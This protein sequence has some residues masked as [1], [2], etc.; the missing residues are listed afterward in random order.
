[1]KPVP[2]IGVLLVLLAALS[3]ANDSQRAWQSGTLLC[4]TTDAL[5]I[6]ASQPNAGRID[7]GDVS[8]ARSHL[9]MPI[10]ETRYSLDSGDFIWVAARVGGY[11]DF[12]VTFSQ[13]MKFAV[14]K[15]NLYLLDAEGKERK[16]KLKE[17]IA[18]TGAVPD[19]ALAP[20]VAEPAAITIV[21][22]PES[23]AI[24]LDGRL[25]GTA[26]ATI[27]LIPGKHDIHLSLKGWKDWSETITVPAGGYLR[28]PVSLQKDRK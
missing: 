16:L 9:V 3:P 8:L 21:S 24:A 28:I 26:P 15:S 22:D 12:Q 18:K 10:N 4:V 5:L 1:M 7:T 27:R 11:S 17:K 6:R 23:A 19:G 14:E 20:A 13:P 2:H 25:V